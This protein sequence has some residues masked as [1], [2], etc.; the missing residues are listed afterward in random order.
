MRVWLAAMVA[1]VVT[2]GSASAVTPGK[3]LFIPSVGRLKG[4]CTKGVCA[5]LRTDVWVYCTSAG[6]PIVTLTFLPRDSENPAPQYTHTFQ[7]VGGQT[8]ELL[9]IFQTVW[10]IDGVAGALRV[11]A[12]DDVA[13]TARVYD[14][15]V[16]TNIGTGTAGQF[17]EGIPAELAL[18]PGESTT[19]VGLAEQGGVWR[20]NLLFVETTGGTVYLWLGRIDASGQS[21]FTNNGYTVRGFE[22]RHINR[23]LQFLGGSG[24]MT[25]QR[26]RVWVQSNSTGRLLVAGSRI[27]SRTG[28]PFTIGMIGD[29]LAAEVD[30]RRGTFMGAFTNPDPAL[31]DGGLRLELERSGLVRFAGMVALPCGG[32]YAVLDLGG[33]V[34]SGTAP[35]GPDGGFGGVTTVCRYNGGDGTALSVTWVLGGVVH[36]DGTVAGSLEALAAGG[37]GAWGSCNGRVALPYSA[38]WTAPP[39]GE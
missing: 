1:L 5:Q 12:Q 19:V 25:N 3:D 23:V 2:A 33:E 35:I 10:G 38:A 32:S 27:D 15:N 17:Y 16:Q 39:A 37:T 36:A 30:R 21:L 4:A 8:V 9:D 29:P 14:A 6:S 18:E 31:V 20:S 34:P 26:V 7:F 28:D 13:V 24:T 11:T 22:A